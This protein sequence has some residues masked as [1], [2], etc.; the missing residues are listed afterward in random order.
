M[1][2]QI[3]YLRRFLKNTFSS[4]VSDMDNFRDLFDSKLDH[5]IF[6]T[7]FLMGTARRQCPS[8]TSQWGLGISIIGSS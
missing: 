2:T 1:K 7:S 8:M 3:M 6:Y 4:K 5:D